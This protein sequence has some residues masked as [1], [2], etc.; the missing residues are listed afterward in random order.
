[1]RGR[2]FIRVRPLTFNPLPPVSGGRGAK[3]ATFSANGSRI[4]AF[5]L[6]RRA[7]ADILGS[8]MNE[9][10]RKK[11]AAAR[12]MLSPCRVC[13][14]D[15]G[16]DRPAGEL[17]TCGIAAEA[18]VS[19]AGPHFGEEPPL[20]GRRGSGT[21]FFAGCNLLCIFCQNHDI[22][23]GR[24]GTPSTPGEI[25]E[26]MG[27][28]E[29]RGCH[30]VN[31]VTPT[32]VMPQLLEAVVAARDKGLR[33]PVVWNCGGY[34]SLEALRF[35]EGHVEIYM[36]DAKF[37]DASTAA[38]LARAPDYP[39]VMRAA[40]REMHRQVGDLVIEHG[41]ARRGLLVRH[42]VMPGCADETRAVIDFLADEISPDTYVNVMGQYRPEYHAR[43]DP[44]VG[45]FP[46][47]EEIESAREH[48]RKR[49]LRLS[50]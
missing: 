30:N 19:S 31:F 33:V 3:Q 49:G 47:H 25:A 27:L 22:S 36:P 29:R 42:L 41:V 9:T 45:R 6:S 44:V 13:P 2:H 50:D 10:Y 28:L 32:H 1:V 35:L 8:A 39:D 18:V 15:C 48:A 26:I 7:P 20:V 14:R 4:T 34:E 46:T 43:A 5:G 11:I 37:A 17:G 16:V 40:L 23:H 24:R 38:R 21:L 12:S